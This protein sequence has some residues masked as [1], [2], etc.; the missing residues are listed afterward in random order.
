M[1]TTEPATAVSAI[2]PIGHDEAMRLAETAYDRFVALA[3]TVRPEQWDLP[4]DCAG[5]TVRDM[6]G[7]VLGAMR[8][9]ASVRELASQQRE[10][11]RRVRRG[12]TNQTDAMTQI[13]IE[14]TA[15]LNTDELVAESRRMVAKATAGRRRIPAPVRRV[16]LRVDLGFLQERWSLGY[17]ND[18]ILTRDAWLHRIDLARALGV[19]PQLTPDH[20]GRII[21]DVVAEWARRHGQAF[22]L[23]LT[24]P[25]GGRFTRGE[26]GADPEVV[27][28]DAVEFCRILSGR[29]QGSGL[30]ATAVP[31]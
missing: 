9:A 23:A 28:L 13:Q 7:H 17:L 15:H 26:E 10:V 30:L 25:A 4:T 5:W 27:G 18:V 14:R 2:A 3:A 8:S 6:V 12:G 19:A 24:G 11:A 31:F 1:T 29:A 22:D 20:D 16:R 21:A